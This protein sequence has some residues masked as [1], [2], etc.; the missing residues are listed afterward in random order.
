MRKCY[1]L[2]NIMNKNTYTRLTVKGDK[3]SASILLN[4]ANVQK[5]R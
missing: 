2:A 1:N 5:Q 4:C 3:Q